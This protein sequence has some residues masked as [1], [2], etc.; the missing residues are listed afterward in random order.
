MILKDSYKRYITGGDMGS[1]AKNMQGLTGGTGPGPGAIAGLVTSFV[2]ALDT[3]NQ[4]GRQSTGTN[5]LK[6]AV[7]G[8][9][10]GSALGPIGM[11]AGAGIGLVSGL[12]TANKQKRVEA[13]AKA[14]EASLARNY[15]LAQYSARAAGDPYLTSG[16]PQEQY[17]SKG[18]SLKTEFMRYKAQGGSLSKLSADSVEVK[19]PSHAQGGVQLPEAQAEVEGGETIKGD[20]VMSKKLGFAQLHKPIAKAIG[21]IEQ[22]P[23][24]ATTLGSL[25]RLRDQEQALML[26]Q[27]YTKAKN[28]LQ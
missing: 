22:K 20:Y 24:T 12:V 9:A 15:Q 14:T 25:Q 8:A 4:Y 26:M 10:A 1:M 18:G 19:G 27:E 17:F 23:V 16:K 7:S 11:A 28:N 5:L 21:Q 3:P 13:T 6:G 2:D